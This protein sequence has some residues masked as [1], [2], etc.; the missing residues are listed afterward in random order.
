MIKQVLNSMVRGN[1]RRLTQ[2]PA[3]KR[4]WIQE[5]TL[6]EHKSNE[7]NPRKARNK[8]IKKINF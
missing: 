4:Q 1:S 3:N 8:S 6:M 7:F 5:I 2:L